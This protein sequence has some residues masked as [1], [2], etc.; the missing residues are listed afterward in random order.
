MEKVSEER[1]VKLV[2]ANRELEAFAS[3]ISHDLRAPLRT[4]QGMAQALRE[5]QGAQWTEEARFY[6]ERIIHA[7]E[8]M[9]HLIRD[10]L[11]YSRMNLAEFELRPVN[12]KT[13]VDD[14]AAMVAA[15]IKERKAKVEFAGVFPM[16][17]ANETLLTEVISNLLINGMKFM[18]EGVTPEIQVTGESRAGRV[19]LSVRDNGI[20]ISPEYHE[21]I[22]KMFERLHTAAEYPGTGVGL[23]IVQ[24]AMARMGGTLGLESTPGK[25]STFW[26]ELPAA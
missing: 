20:G 17:R 5:D 19:R 18:A 13:T 7:S 24:R 23:A 8:R 22:F 2:A 3:T 6:T 15:T 14:V 21:R 25:G 12:L 10:L 11:E 26:I 16:V 9:D 4:M 1:R